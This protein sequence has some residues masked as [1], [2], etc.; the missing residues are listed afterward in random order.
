MRCHVCGSEI[1]NG[2][3]FC[4]KCGN[5]VAKLESGSGVPEAKTECPKCRKMK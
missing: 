1:E 4:A 3:K 2:V 5:P